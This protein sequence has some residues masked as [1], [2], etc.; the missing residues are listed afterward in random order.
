MGYEGS[1]KSVPE[2]AKELGATTVLEG[3]VQRSGDRI[4]MNVQLIDARTDEHLWAER[5]DRT[6]TAGDVFAIQAEIAEEI[7]RALETALTPEQKAELA[8]AP[9][10]NLEALDLYYQGLAYNRSRGGYGYESARRA[11]STLAAAVEVDPE[12]AV[13]WAALALARGW[14]LRIGVSTDTTGAREAL[15]RAVALAP[16][17]RETA[18]AEGVYLYF[19]KADFAEA[20]DRFQKALSRWP[21]DPDLLGWRAIVVRRLGRWEESVELGEKARALDPRNPLILTYLGETFYNLRRYDEGERAFDQLLALTPRDGTAR[22]WKILLLLEGRGDLARA[23]RF[24]EASAEDIGPPGHA[25]LAARVAFYERDY[26]EGIAALE[27]QPVEPD[28]PT[29]APFWLALLSHSAGREAEVRA[30][31]DS[32]AATAERRIAELES[33]H[34]PFAQRTEAIALRGIANALSGRR[35]EAVRDA[36]HA[37]DL[38]P[39]SR[40]AVDGPGLHLLVATLLVLAGERDSAFRLLDT[41]ASVPGD[42]TAAS[43]RLSPVYDSLRDDPRYA[44]LLRKLEAAEQS[45]TGTR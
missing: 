2:I 12:F 16:D 17:A 31:A 11:E 15:D 45:G 43:L 36:R 9:T 20:E 40:D 32:L 13:A 19:A 30:W 3:G 35:S 41:L 34:D 18:L 37:I 24:L 5:Y 44:V 38:L 42:L 39:L 33:G 23:K 6:L 27:G 10:E 7:A 8:S 22:W 1:T 4:R 25:I 21:D 26:R 28:H 14:Q 29:D